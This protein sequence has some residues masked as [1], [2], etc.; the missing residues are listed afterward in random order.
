MEPQG[1][2]RRETVGKRPL[3]LSNCRAAG[4][5]SSGSELLSP[6]R[7]EKD[8]SEFFETT[9]PGSNLERSDRGNVQDGWYAGG[10]AHPGHIR[11]LS[12]I[13]CNAV[14][15]T[16][17]FLGTDGGWSPK[18]GDTFV[19]S[20]R[21]REKQNWRDGR[22]DQSRLN[23]DVYGWDRCSRGCSDD[24]HRTSLCST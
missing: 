5:K 22:Y 6:Q 12:P 23:N 11:G 4:G 3:L 19:P 13:R 9:A 14:T 7:M 17:E 15:Q 1:L 16:F 24:N 18:L 10:C 8:V 20:G 21:N 2:E